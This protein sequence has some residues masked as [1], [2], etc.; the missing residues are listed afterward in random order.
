MKLGRL[1]VL[2]CCEGRPFDSG[3]CFPI[4]W[5]LW[6]GIGRFVSLVEFVF[7]FCDF[8]WSYIA[9]WSLI[10]VESSFFSCFSEIFRPL[11][12]L[13]L[14]MVSVLV[15]YL[16]FALRWIQKELG[17]AVRWTQVYLGST[18]T[19]NSS[20]VWF[21]C[22]LNSR[23]VGCKRVM[24]QLKVGHECT[25]VQYKIGHGENITPSLV[26]VFVWWL[27]NMGGL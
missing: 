2:T 3:D 19:L 24:T 20:V 16:G 11:P 15:A 23:G 13:S 17:S 12:C 25:P 10:E 9:W 21:S 8:L 1:S 5:N 18:C 26:M 6:A 7:F 27:L 4:F 22:R 14:M